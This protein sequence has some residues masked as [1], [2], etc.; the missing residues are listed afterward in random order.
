MDNSPLRRRRFLI[1]AVGASALLAG[2]SDRTA[3]EHTIADGPLSDRPSEGEYDDG[4]YH[5][6]D[7]GITWR[8]DAS[9]EDWVYFSGQGVLNT[10]SQGRVTSMQRILVT[11]GLKRLLYG[12]SRPMGSKVTVRLK[13]G[14]RF[15]TVSRRLTRPAAVSCTSRPD[16]TFS[17]V[18]RSLEMIPS[19]WVQVDRQSS[20]GRVPPTRKA[21][22]S[23]P[24]VGTTN[25]S[26]AARRTG[27]SATSRS[28]HL[29]QMALCLHMPRTSGWRIS[30]ATKSTTTTS[31]SSRQKTSSWM[32]TGQ[33]AAGKATPTR[34]F[35]STI[36]PRAQL[37]T[38]CGTETAIHLQPND[39]TP[40][41]NY[42]LRDF[43]IDPANGPSNGV[44]LHRDGNKTITIE[45]GYI[46]GYEY[47]AI[48]ADTGA[49]LED[50]TVDRIS[51]IENARGVSLGHKKSGRR[52]LA[53]SNVTVRTDN[54]T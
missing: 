27:E 47:A 41:S 23:S 32:A 50:L 3:D 39:G 7:Q 38:A 12:T 13:L 36:R 34:R 26:T 4:L 46:T 30:M 24:T 31:I 20:R 44:H 25:R 45:D 18:H 49:L 14:T 40:T 9:S 6:S 54:S 10:Q 8:W 33:L 35:S 52:E 37:P 19:S 28:T 22:R 48:R 43:T 15:T 29:R 5:A 51:C 42:A 17:N 2:C 1:G 11:R 53:I 16:G 21:E